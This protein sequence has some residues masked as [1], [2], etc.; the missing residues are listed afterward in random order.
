MCTNIIDYNFLLLALSSW[1]RWLLLSQYTRDQDT[2]KA[3]GLPW[4]LMG[5]DNICHISQG[6][7]ASIVLCDNT[8]PIHIWLY[9]KI[10][11]GIID[12]NYPL[13]ALSPGVRWLLLLQYKRYQVKQKAICLP[14]FLM[15]CDNSCHII[16]GA[17]AS[18]V[19]C[20]NTLRIYIWLYG[21]ICTD[22]I[23]YNYPLLALSS[24]VRWLLLLQ[25]TRN[26]D[27]QQAYMLALIPYWLWQ[28]KSHYPRSQ[29]KQRAIL[30]S[31][32]ASK[33]Y[34]KSV[35]TLLGHSE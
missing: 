33:L 19:V 3:I 18:T 32:N 28:Q 25:Y 7:K 10:C 8:S 14:W 24:W 15:G 31:D 6:A 16:Q 2:Q 4:L 26:Q 22:M 11:T 1:V 23:A 20:D 21:K 17:K 35:F 5:H 9:C 34:F 12:Y 29:G 27:K 13:L 30:I